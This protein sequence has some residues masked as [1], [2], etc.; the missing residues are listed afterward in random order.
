MKIYQ[1]ILEKKERGQ[2]MLAILID[3][4]KTSQEECLHLLK[5]AV[6]FPPDVFLVGGSLMTRDH[7]ELIVSTLK[8]HTQV[9]VVLFPG[10][11]AHLTPLADGLLFLSL[12][13][14]RNPE[15]LIGQQVVAAPLLR[16]MPIEVM[17]TGYLLVDCGK[18]TTVS[19]ISNTTPVPYDKPEIA[20]CTAMAAEL[21]GMKM[22]YADG[23]SGAARPISTHM[24][25]AIRKSID[26]P[27]IIGGGIT[28][29]QAAAAAYQ[30]GADM[31]VVGTAIERSPTFLQ[32]LFEV[33]FECSLS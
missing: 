13:S 6:Q 1:Q 20:A 22:I 11:Y 21:I 30:A 32:D 12:I 7:L 29:P 26:L 9:P 25:R 33:R 19:Y 8:E 23:G 28:S 2:K 10:N 17:S 14:G 16:Q 31:L 3:P 27:L 24:V 4:D 18:Q 15:Y 5:I